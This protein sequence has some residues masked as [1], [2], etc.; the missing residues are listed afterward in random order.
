VIGGGAVYGAFLPHADRL[1]I[2]DV[3]VAVDGDTWAPAIG[4]GW[5]LAG[6][7]PDRGWDFSPSSG[8]RYA[9]SE[10]VR[11]PVPTAG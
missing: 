5:R 7:T 3:D 10:Y 6:R 2:T 9:V 8:L 4:A 11:D 1:V